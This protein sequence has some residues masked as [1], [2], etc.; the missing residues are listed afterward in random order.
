MLG[1]KILN[2]HIYMYII[3]I[4]T[5]DTFV[6]YTFWTYF[7]SLFWVFLKLHDEK[8]LNSCEDKEYATRKLNCIYVYSS[9]AKA[10]IESFSES[11]FKFL[12]SHIMF[13]FYISVRQENAG[14][15]WCKLCN[16]GRK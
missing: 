11:G 1:F 4:V 13:N 2:C 3:G 12:K 9:K 10:F 15:K 7:N 14:R 16:S 6:V 5:L 8:Y